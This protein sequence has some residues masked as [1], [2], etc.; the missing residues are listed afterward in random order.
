MRVNAHDCARRQAPVS[1]RKKAAA[2]A[3]GGGNLEI[4]LLDLIYAIASLSLRGLDFQAVLLGRG[5]EKSPDRMFLP[6]RGFHN[7]GQGR[8]L[9]PPDQFQD[10]CALAFSAR[11]YRSGES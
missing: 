3:S 4:L 6:I 2:L 7:L 10:L 5:R 11:S 9:G 1:D 8:P